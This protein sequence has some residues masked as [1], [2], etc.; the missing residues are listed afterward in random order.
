MFGAVKLTKNADINKYKSSG[1]G[2]GFDGKVAFSHPSGV[3]GN[4]AI[5]FGV[6]IS[7]HYNGANS[8]LLV[9]GAEIHKFQK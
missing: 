2:I 8:Y 4:N 3:F 5:I 1:Y 6:D 7:L 9:N